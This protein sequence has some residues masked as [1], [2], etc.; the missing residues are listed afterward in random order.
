MSVN[1]PQFWRDPQLPF[2]EARA[3]AD[4]RK[5][6]YA[7]HSHEIFSIGTITDGTSTYSNGSRQL[8]VSA[9]DVVI[10]NPQQVHACNPIGDQRWSYIMFYIDTAWLGEL[11]REIAGGGSGFIPFKEVLSRDPLLFNGLNRLYE[12][13]VD[14]QCC[15]LEK[16]IALVEY[17]TD[18]QI[19]LGEA[20]PPAVATHP[21]LEAAAAFISQHCTRPLTLEAICRAAALSPSYLI[22]AFKQHYGMTP[23]AYLVNRRI[24]FGHR[25]LK[26]GYPIAAAASESG[27]ADQAHFQRTFKQLLAATPGQYQ[28]PR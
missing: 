20:H 18:L 1:A 8:Q 24:Q 27:F 22:R 15:H 28:N 25:L 23:H 13:L 2:V 14:P 11:Q 17:F 6:C 21:R 10:I 12:L 4:G 5:V 26:R 19:R 9:G 7:P 16:H 3:I